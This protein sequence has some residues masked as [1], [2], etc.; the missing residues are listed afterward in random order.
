ML[1]V[2]TTKTNVVLGQNLVPNPSFE[3]ID[4]C[5]LFLGDFTLIDWVKPTWGS[6]DNFH[7]CSTGQL[8]VPQ[9]IVGWQIPRTGNAYAGTFGAASPPNNARE[10]LQCQ[11]LTPLEG[12]E[13]YEISFWVSRA[14]SSTIA[15]DNLGAYL[16]ATEVSGSFNEN[17]PFIPQVISFY[18]SPIVEAISWVQIIDTITAVGGEYYL[19]LGVFTDVYNTNC[20]TAIGGWSSDFYYYFDDVSVIKTAEVGLTELI[21]TDI[22]IFPNPTA[23]NIIISSNE[24]IESYTIFSSLGQIVIKEEISI[25]TYLQ[26]IDLSLYS[27]GVYFIIINTSKSAIRKKFI[28]NR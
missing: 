13:K 17:L 10:Y 22:S 15:C 24:P 19:T 25:N 26:N 27:T 3:E 4:S 7:T 16:S 20:T 2:F 28:I 1:F 21:E 18:N 12:G 6:S 23:G 11:L 8:G 9:N 14:D 5:P